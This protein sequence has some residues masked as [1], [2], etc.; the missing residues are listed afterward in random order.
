MIKIN[1]ES[2][3]AFAYIKDKAKWTTDLIHGDDIPA[4]KL[5]NTDW[6]DFKDPIVGTLIPN[7]FISYFG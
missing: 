2:I 7:N 1:V 3:H 5:T 6:K 4:D